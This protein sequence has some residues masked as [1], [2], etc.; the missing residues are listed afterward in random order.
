MTRFL[1]KSLA[2]GRGVKATLPSFI[3][4]KSQPIAGEV[5]LA[6]YQ[7]LYQGFFDWDGSG[8]GAGAEPASNGN[9]AVFVP[10]IK[11]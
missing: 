11:P 3:E 6:N 10:S 2:C 5:L 1:I 8:W 4:S 9:G 7:T